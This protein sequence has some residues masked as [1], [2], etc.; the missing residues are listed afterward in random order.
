MAIKLKVGLSEAS[1]LKM[2]EA[3]V[4]VKTPKDLPK[5]AGPQCTKCGHIKVCAVFRAIAP[6]ME[7][8]KKKG[9][10]PPF[11][12]VEMAKICKNYLPAFLVPDV[13]A[14]AIKP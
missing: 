13:T 4:K 5:E 10:E 6:L 14:S 1:G 3:A 9:G 12:A 11:E 2:N 8:F 7:D